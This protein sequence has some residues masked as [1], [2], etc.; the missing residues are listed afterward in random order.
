MRTESILMTSSLVIDFGVAVAVGFSDGAVATDGPMICLGTGVGLGFCRP[1]C[2]EAIDATSVAMKI[3]AKN[4]IYA[5]EK[6]PQL[7]I[8]NNLCQLPQ[9]DRKRPACHRRPF[10]VFKP[11]ST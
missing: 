6:S 5:V 8:I 7:L 2:A 1:D 4:L 11:E 9:L 10:A 3:R